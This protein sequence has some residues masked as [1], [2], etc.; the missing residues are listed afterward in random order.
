[1]TIYVKY[2]E[3]NIGKSWKK[4]EEKVMFGVYFDDKILEGDK[5]GEAE[6]AIR[7][8]LQR[9]VTAREALKELCR[10][11]GLSAYKRVKKEEKRA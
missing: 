4:R 6:R 1:M 2:Y 7:L 3:Y 10:R 11:K 8:N 5:F 9:N